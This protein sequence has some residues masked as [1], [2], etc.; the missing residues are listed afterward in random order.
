MQEKGR[1]VNGIY[2]PYACPLMDPE[3]LELADLIIATFVG[4]HKYTYDQIY[5]A[6]SEVKD[7]VR[8]L[9]QHEKP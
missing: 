9:Q 6:L 8:Y 7:E 3:D 1:L 2:I 4:T 5:G